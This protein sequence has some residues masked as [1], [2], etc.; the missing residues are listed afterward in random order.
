[1][2]QLV[3]LSTEV[4]PFSSEALR[5]VLDRARTNNQACGV[6]G[7]LLHRGGRFLQVLEGEEPVVRALIDR[8]VRD[9]RHELAATLYA[10]NVETREF[11]D[12]SMGFRDLDTSEPLPLGFS[13]FLDSS[14]SLASFATD[15][16]RAKQLL[17][18]F[19]SSTADRAA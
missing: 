14:L 16:P 2:F 11:P 15:P 9:P 3:Y 1:M 18:A 4:V 10:G 13:R 7:M 12:W 8:I 6:T 5:A 17:L 19:K